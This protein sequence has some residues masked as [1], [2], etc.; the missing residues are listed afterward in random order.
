MPSPVG[1]PHALSARTLTL[2]NGRQGMVGRGQP[3]AAG[4]AMPARGRARGAP[5]Y[6]PIPGYPPQQFTAPFQPPGPQQAR[7]PYMVGRGAPRAP[8][9][10][11]MVYAPTGPA[12]GRAAYGRGAQRPYRPVGPQPGMG[13]PAPNLTAEAMSW[14]AATPSLPSY[15]VSEPLSASAAAEDDANLA[16]EDECCVCMERASTSLTSNACADAIKL[17]ICSTTGC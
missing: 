5:A 16:V 9:P 6:Q 8:M 7:P 13:M 12:A 15:A 3:A 2:C 4:R 11:G 17:M 1:A 10:P 14:S